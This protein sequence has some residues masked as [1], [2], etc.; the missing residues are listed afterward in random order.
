MRRGVDIVDFSLNG[1]PWFFINS[2]Q[3]IYFFFFYAP[4]IVQL[5]FVSLPILKKM[6]KF[7]KMRCNAIFKSCRFMIEFRPIPKIKLSLLFERSKIFCRIRV[8][9]EA[10]VK[11]FL[12]IHPVRHGSMADFKIFSQGIK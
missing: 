5:R 6:H 9:P 12:N 8:Y 11:G 1:K 10:I 2:H 7:Y 3:E 4:K